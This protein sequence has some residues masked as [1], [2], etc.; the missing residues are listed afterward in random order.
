MLDSLPASVL[1]PLLAHCSVPSLCA[2]SGTCRA[3]RR[4]AFA[5]PPGPQADCQPSEH[6]AP[7]MAPAEVQPSPWLY[8]FPREREG[9]ALHMLEELHNQV[10]PPP[11]LHCPRPSSCPHDLRLVAA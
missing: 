9:F 6:R 7:G 5:P 3:L 2:L 8:L 1:Q 10:M 4:L 11:S